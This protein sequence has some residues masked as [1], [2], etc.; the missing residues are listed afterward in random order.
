[1]SDLVEVKFDAPALPVAGSAKQI[2]EL[3]VVDDQVTCD[4][5]D[6]RLTRLTLDGNAFEAQRKAIVDPINQAKNAVQA[7]F[8]PVLD[9]IDEAKG[10]IKQKILAF[11][12]EQDRKRDQ[13]QAALDRA[14]REHRAKLEAQA[15]KAADKGN[16]E[17]AA[18]LAAT[19]AVISAPIA[20][21][22]YV[23]P[24]G[25]SIR[26]TW[27]VRITDRVKLIASILANP[28]FAYLLLIDEAAL[29]KLAVA[30]HGKVPLDGVESYEE[31]ILVKRVA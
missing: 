25:Q 31:E 7:L 16:V 20:T 11:R 2:A 9:D 5:A 19:A 13:E 15:E 3:V 22:T 6:E 29:N 18:V 28:A 27:K 21:S 26:K 17:K 12:R 4:L 14:A 1:M 30:M 10:I 8:K 23:A 24:K